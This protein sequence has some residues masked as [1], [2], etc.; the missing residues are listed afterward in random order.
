MRDCPTFGQWQLAAA[1]RG[2]FGSLAI[3][4]LS[5]A[6]AQS[7]RSGWLQTRLCPATDASAALV[8]LSP[9]TGAR[10][11]PRGVGTPQPGLVSRAGRRLARKRAGPP[12]SSAPRSPAPP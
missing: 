8:G 4:D 7:G 2:S 3:N 5:R 9:R 10:P 6:E 12:A 11:A 1:N